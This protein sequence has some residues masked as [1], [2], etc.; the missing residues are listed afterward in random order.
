MRSLGPVKVYKSYTVEQYDKAGC[1]LMK[2]EDG[3]PF[4]LLHQA[5]KGIVCHGCWHVDK[6]CPARKKLVEENP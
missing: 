2:D 3:L 5:A 4:P 6:D 1:L